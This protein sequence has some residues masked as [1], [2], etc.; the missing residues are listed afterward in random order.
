VEL[1]RARTNRADK[2]A[3]RAFRLT[4]ATAGCLLLAVLAAVAVFLIVQALPA[5]TASSEELVDGNVL[6]QGMTN[7]WQLVGPL[8]F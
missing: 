3:S 7:I 8:V 5:L 2:G 1:R 6:P 4:S